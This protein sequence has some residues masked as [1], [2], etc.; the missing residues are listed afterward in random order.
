MS[1]QHQLHQLVEKENELSAG[2]QAAL[3]KSEKEIRDYNDK[4]QESL[5]S[6]ALSPEVTKEI[7]KIMEKGKKEESLIMAKFTESI[8][9]DLS[10]FNDNYRQK[11]LLLVKKL[12]ENFKNKYTM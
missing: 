3:E 5:N 2:W 6:L 10:F 4:Q 7:K 1:G 9:K 11:E 8:E 12:M